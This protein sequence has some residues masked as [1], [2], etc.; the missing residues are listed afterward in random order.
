M[1]GGP[2]NGRPSAAARLVTRARRPAVR[3]PELFVSHAVELEDAVPASTVPAPGAPP[4]LRAPRP[5]TVARPSSRP[6]PVEA[7][8]PVVVR[9]PFAA[10]PVAAQA[11]VRR[12]AVAEQAP[13]PESHRPVEP[14]PPQA[15]AAFP[16]GL[17]TWSPVE[18]ASIA[19]PPALEPQ[20]EPPGWQSLADPE[21]DEPSQRVQAP[22]EQ[23]RRVAERMP[24]REVPAPTI[25]APPIRGAAVPSPIRGVAVPPPSQ[26]LPP[27]AAVPQVLIDRIE[28]VT[29]PARAPAPDPFRSLASR[30]VGASRHGGAS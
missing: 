21:P 10:P 5:A 14:S 16:E 28:V 2:T 8:P 30:R 22:A 1:T 25:V 19:V 29:P 24:S 17:P 18:L 12:A 9:E 3:A 20:R 6:T 27:T 7:P 13:A 26:P 4:I 15:E 23:P 11:G